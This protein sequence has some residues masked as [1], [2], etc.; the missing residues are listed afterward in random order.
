MVQ[1]S[2]KVGLKHPLQWSLL[3]LNT[4]Y[5]NDTFWGIFGPNN[6]IFAD[7]GAEKQNMIGQIFLKPKS[8]NLEMKL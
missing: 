5:R 6:V 3:S 2:V 1:N 7:T 8:N 4:M